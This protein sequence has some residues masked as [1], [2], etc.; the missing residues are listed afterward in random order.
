MTSTWIQSAPAAVT[1]SISDPRA[2]KSADRMDAAMRT[3]CCGMTCPTAHSGPGPGRRLPALAPEGMDGEASERFELLRE[4]LEFLQSQRKPALLRMALDLG[5]EL[6]LLEMWSRE[7]A[8]ELHDV[9]AVGGKSA[10][11]LVE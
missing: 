3:G 2:A 7:I 6:R 11:R 5:V 9:D 1:A 4:E 8:F 10:Q